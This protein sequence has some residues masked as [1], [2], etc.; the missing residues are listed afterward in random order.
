MPRLSRVDSTQRGISNAIRELQDS[1]IEIGGVAIHHGNKVLIG[2]P[3]TQPALS[4][5]TRESFRQL[6]NLQR[7]GQA[8]ATTTHRIQ[9]NGDRSMTHK[10]ISKTKAAIKR[11][12]YDVQEQLALIRFLIAS[13]YASAGRKKLTKSQLKSL[14]T[15]ENKLGLQPSRKHSKKHG[16]KHRTPSR[17]RTSTSGKP[18]RHMSPGQKAALRKAIKANPKMKPASKRKALAK[19]S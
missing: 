19:L 4:R 7:M 10:S 9:P 13:I 5:G 16:K 11:A 3:K 17:R 1:G 6:P 8:S 12:K 18:K 2:S 15:A 14:A